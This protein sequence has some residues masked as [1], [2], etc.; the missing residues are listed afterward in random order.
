MYDDTCGGCT[1]IIC[2]SCEC[3]VASVWTCL[4]DEGDAASCVC[5][6][7]VDACTEKKNLMKADTRWVKDLH[8]FFYSIFNA[9]TAYDLFEKKT[10]TKVKFNTHRLFKKTKKTRNVIIWI[11]ISSTC[12]AKTGRMQEIIRYCQCTIRVGWS[13]KWFFYR[14]SFWLPYETYLSFWYCP[15]ESEEWRSAPLL[16]IKYRNNVDID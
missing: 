13:I 7:A 1:I 3:L 15:D 14:I 12:T 10:A 2:H 16:L 11:L 4:A 6:F 5:A 9:I 8:F